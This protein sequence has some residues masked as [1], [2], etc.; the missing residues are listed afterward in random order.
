M[1][2]RSLTVTARLAIEGPDGAGVA[3]GGGFFAL[4]DFEPFVPPD[5]LNGFAELFFLN[6]RGIGPGVFGRNAIFENQGAL[7][8]DRKLHAL[9]APADDFVVRR[10]VRSLGLA[11]DD[12][13]FDRLLEAEVA[14]SGF[15]GTGSPFHIDRG[16]LGE[17]ELARLFVALMAMI[18]RLGLFIEAEKTAFGGGFVAG[19]GVVEMDIGGGPVPGIVRQANFDVFEALGIAL[20]EPALADDFA[21]E[22][23]GVGSLG[24]I[25]IEPSIGRGGRIRR[26]LRRG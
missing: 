15:G 19:E 13:D 20:E 7:E 5:F 4:D 23:E 1:E 8:V 14:E 6:R 24:I 21:N 26:D 2:D 3:G 18:Q 17:G 25:V 11:I 10:E 22:R 12:L 16:E 9:A